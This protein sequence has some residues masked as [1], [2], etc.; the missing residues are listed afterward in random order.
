MPSVSNL[1]NASACG[2]NASSAFSCMPCYLAVARVFVSVNGSLWNDPVALHFC[3][4]SMGL[5][6][7]SCAPSLI[8]ETPGVLL[9]FQDY[10]NISEGMVWIYGGYAGTCFRKTEGSNY[11]KS[12]TAGMVVTGTTLVF[13]SDPA[14][15]WIFWSVYYDD[16]CTLQAHTFFVGRYTFWPYLQDG[17]T[18]TVQRISVVPV[19]LP[20]LYLAGGLLFTLYDEPG[21]SGNV[22]WFEW[23][24]LSNP[25]NIQPPLCNDD[26]RPCL[27]LTLT[28]NG[29][30]APRPLACRVR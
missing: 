27:S 5:V 25:I 10:D 18:G 23:F 21:C 30:Y 29:A 19:T 20:P 13:G 2:A 22:T 14:V 16:I 26:V 3:V 24:P 4:I 1:Y 12:D 9:E 28:A 7:Q 11:N 6:P 15:S 17:F 8:Q